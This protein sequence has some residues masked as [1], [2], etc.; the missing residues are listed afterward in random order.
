MTHTKVKLTHISLKALESGH[1]YSYPIYY[2]NTNNMFKT[3]VSANEKYGNEVLDTIKA[4]K[5]R[6]A[7]VLTK[8]H[9]QYETD[10]QEYMSKL[11]YDDSVSVE[12]KSKMLQEMAADTMNELFLG[13]L[14]TDKIERT[15]ALLNDTISLVF[16]DKSAIK[17][18]MGVT[19]YDYYTYTHS[20]N[21]SIYAVGFA[22]YLKF[23]QKDIHT[24]GMA[25]ILHDLGKK[26]IP[27]EIV[28]KKGKLT[29]EEFTIM[30]NHSSYSVRILKEM[31][32]TDALM[33]DIIE[34]HHEKLD[35]SG[36]PYGLKADEI[37]F[38]SQIISICDIFDALTTKRSYKNALQ[39]Y[40][41]LT[42]M[43]HNMSNELN[44]KLLKKFINFMNEK[45]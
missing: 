3:L 27:T 12:K 9:N 6:D 16:N 15:S 20:V 2:K 26:D 33:L 19:S 32:N 31:G 18:M 34:Q 11:I 37:H 28:N 40:D 45:V 41:A 36:Y 1:I 38:F 10:T 25:A 29:D 14:N 24:I 30:K 21:V 42:I 35:G 43:Y 22:S 23:P 4:L 7:Y 44:L 17:A 8:D 13:D 39:S 5:I